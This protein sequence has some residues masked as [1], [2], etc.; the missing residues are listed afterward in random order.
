[1]KTGLLTFDVE[2]WFSVTDFTGL[3]DPHV[4][5]TLPLRLDGPIHFLLDLLEETHTKSTFFFVSSIAQQIPHLV[6]QIVKQGHEIACHSATHRLLYDLTDDE[7]HA[8]IIDSKHMLEDISGTAIQG[9]RAPTFSLTKHSIPYLANAGY[10]YD[11]SLW[12]GKIDLLSE[13]NKAGIS[14][15]SIS[16]RKIL[17]RIVPMGG[18]YLRL[19]GVGFYNLLFRKGPE[20]LVVYLHPWE[21]DTFHPRLHTASPWKRFKHYIGLRDMTSKLLV[22]LRKANWMS[23]RKALVR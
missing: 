10:K 6:R 18:G 22:L 12:T 20:P 11:S 1:M 23:C 4:A 15:F 9:F 13:L 14:E 21:F 17:N 7:L 3:L 8:E 19:L 2:T 5:N 16:I